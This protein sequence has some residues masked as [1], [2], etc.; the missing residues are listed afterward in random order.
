VQAGQDPVE[1]SEVVGGAAAGATDATQNDQ[2]A[3]QSAA[4]ERIYLGLRTLDG[5]EL[6]EAELPLVGPWVQMG[7]AKLLGPRRLVLTAR[8]WLR[9]DSLAMQLL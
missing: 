1:G 6:T 9:L 2:A 5:L 7:W 8:G 4:A 3:A